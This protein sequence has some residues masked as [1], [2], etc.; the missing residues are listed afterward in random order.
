[1]SDLQVVAK[2]G[3]K[4]ARSDDHVNPTQADTEGGRL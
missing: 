3:S 1:M 2:A 4:N